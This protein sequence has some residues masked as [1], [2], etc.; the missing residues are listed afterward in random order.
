[1]TQSV[2]IRLTDVL[3]VPSALW[4][5]T[6]SHAFNSTVAAQSLVAADGLQSMASRY[7]TELD[8]AQASIQGI[9]QQLRRDVGV[10]KV[11]EKPT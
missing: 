8:T 10:T 11:A 9:L 2:S 3:L 7:V 5:R 4:Q 1:M 6:L